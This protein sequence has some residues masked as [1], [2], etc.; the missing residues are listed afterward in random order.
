MPAAPNLPAAVFFDAY[1]TLISWK[2]ARPPAQVV[3]EGLWAAGVDAPFERVEVAVRAEMAFYRERQALV[4]TAAELD[5]LRIL[6]EDSG[7]SP[8]VTKKILEDNPR[9]F[10][11]I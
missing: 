5:A 4:R 11:G 10:Y 6:R 7:L 3:A 2:P 9:A 1:G 8:S